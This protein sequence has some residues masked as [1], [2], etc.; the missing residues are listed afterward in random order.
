LPPSLRFSKDEPSEIEIK[1][2][3]Q[4]LLL[5]KILLC[6]EVDRLTIINKQLLDEI[7]VYTNAYNTFKREIEELRRKLA[8]YEERDPVLG[9]LKAELEKAQEINKK[10]WD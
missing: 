1:P 7:I 3:N 6:S 9:A 2:I 10:L 4:D 8:E 5:E